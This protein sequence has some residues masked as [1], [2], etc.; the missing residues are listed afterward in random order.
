MTLEEKLN[1]FTA[2]LE[3][4]VPLALAE[5]PALPVVNEFVNEPDGDIETRKCYVYNYEGKVDL[6]EI[7][8]MF[9]VTFQLPGINNPQS[10]TSRILAVVINFEASF[11]ADI[12]VNYASIFMHETEDG[13][14]AYS[15]FL[16]KIDKST[17]DCEEF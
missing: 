12:E 9:I 10:Y 14:N 13:Q 5:A 4:E 6:L 3:Q 7:T 8:D 2:Y 11:G 1:E 15:E 16:V 17:D